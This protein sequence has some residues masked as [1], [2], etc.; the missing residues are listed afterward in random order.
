MSFAYAY[1]IALFQ[2]SQPKQSTHAPQVTCV[3]RARQNCDF[4]SSFAQSSGGQ[5]I[6]ADPEI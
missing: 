6:P 4:F 2:E 1:S 3:W 5:Q